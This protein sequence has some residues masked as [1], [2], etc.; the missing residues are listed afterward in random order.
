MINKES[1][2][3]KYWEVDN[4]YA[5]SQKS[6]I[7]E[8]IWVESR[9]EFNEDFRKDCNE[10]SDLWYF[11]EVDVQYPEWLHEFYNALPFL[12]VRMKI[13]NVEKVIADLSNKKK[14]VAHIL[15]LKASTKSWKSIEKNNWNY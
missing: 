2:C 4:L 5:M 13:K 6:S 11:L 7:G 9:S 10:D 12:P 1:S 8:F 15:N 3:L 14:Y